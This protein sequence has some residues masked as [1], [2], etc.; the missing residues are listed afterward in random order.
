M[1]S[2]GAT[3]RTIKTQ[4]SAAATVNY[5]R[6]PAGER[7]TVVTSMKG[8]RVYK[9]WEDRSQELA[10]I[11]GLSLDIDPKHG[12]TLSFGYIVVSIAAWRSKKLSSL[13][14]YHLAK[15]ALAGSALTICVIKPD[16]TLAGYW[17]R[18]GFDYNQAKIDFFEEHLKV[19]YAHLN[20]T[21]DQ[22]V[23]MV[24][25]G[26]TSSVYTANVSVLGYWDEFFDVPL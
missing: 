7:V 5:Y 22:S 25:Y 8:I 26:S 15:L 16:A 6:G 21:L 19:Q 18:V 24:A 11:D 20:P 1:Q 12:K 23:P 4:S 10:H 17:Q 3:R 9:G 2:K 14:L 13:M